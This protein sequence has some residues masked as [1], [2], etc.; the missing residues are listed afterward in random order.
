MK[1]RVPTEEDLPATASQGDTYVVEET[2]HAWCWS[3]SESA[4]IDVGKIQGPQGPAGLT[5]PAGPAGPA[6][7]TGPAGADADMAV[8][9]ALEARVAALEAKLA[10]N[11]HITGDITASGNITAYA[12]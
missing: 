10:A 2:S 8:I 7:P 3:E 5:G 12:V 4:F 1:G 6:G 11:L 9:T